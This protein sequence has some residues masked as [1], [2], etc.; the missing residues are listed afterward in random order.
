MVGI[1]QPIRVLVVDD[2]AMVRESLRLFISTFDDLEC[3][4]EAING[5]EAIEMCSTESPHVILMDV[6]MPEVNGITATQLIHA[7]HPH[8]KIIALTSLNDENLIAEILA[9]GAEV[10]LMKNAPIDALANAIRSAYFG[11]QILPQSKY[12]NGINNNSAVS[13]KKA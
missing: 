7:T 4:G 8:I 9:A 3:I 2:H 6:S 12:R 1:D 5:E 10:A 13:K 11:T